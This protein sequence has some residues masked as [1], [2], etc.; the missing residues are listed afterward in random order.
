MLVGSLSVLVGSL[1]V[2]VRSPPV[3]AG[4][5][6]VLVG[7]LSVLAGAV[8][9]L[10]VFVGVADLRY[11]LIG[12]TI[13]KKLDKYNVRQ[14]SRPQWRHSPL[15]QHPPDHTCVDLED[16]PQFVQASWVPSASSCRTSFEPYCGRNYVPTDIDISQRSRAHKLTGS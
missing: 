1:S 4:S 13:A 14:Y 8:N 9:A 12:L 5:L 15:P 7:S 6:L 2:L 11:V 10:P 3:L 16:D